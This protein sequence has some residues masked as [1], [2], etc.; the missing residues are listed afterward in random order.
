LTTGARRRPTRNV[1]RKPKFHRVG[2]YSCPDSVPAPWL[3]STGTI[4]TVSSVQAF[5]APG[6]IGT[7]FPSQ[8]GTQLPCR[9]DSSPLRVLGNANAMGHTGGKER[10]HEQPQ[11]SPLLEQALPRGGPEG[12]AEAE[13]LLERARAGR[14]GAGRGITVP[15]LRGA[16]ASLFCWARLAG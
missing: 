6:R 10:G 11:R 2:A 12:S 1:S 5:V 4:T 15:S 7:R 9:R 16:L 8:I 13:N 14:E 3:P